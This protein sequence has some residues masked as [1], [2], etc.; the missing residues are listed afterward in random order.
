M[1]LYDIFVRA[2]NPRL[3]MNPFLLGR[4]QMQD[5]YPP[6]AKNRQTSAPAA[7]RAGTR[8]SSK[9]GGQP[10]MTK[11]DRGLSVTSSR[12]LGIG[13][14]IKCAMDPPLPPIR[15]SYQA[16]RDSYHDTYP[17]H[18]DTYPVH[19][20]TYPVS[21]DTY[22]VRCDTYPMSGSTY[23]NMFYNSFQERDVPG[24]RPISAT[25]Q[26]Q[27]PIYGKKQFSNAINNPSHGAPKAYFGSYNQNIGT[28]SAS[29]LAA[30]QGGKKS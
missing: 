9:Y 12:M 30:I 15:S 28:I 21:G 5:P 10:P 2:Q 18:G 22:P 6:I 27:K 13:R 29:G 19:G 25:S 3:Q 11:D 1:Q 20:D 17:V 26:K 8:P 4:N 7:T 24:Q 16:Y 14:L 23:H